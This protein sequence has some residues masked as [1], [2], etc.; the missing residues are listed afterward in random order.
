MSVSS[1]DPEVHADGWK[2]AA[3]PAPRGSGRVA[4]R[5]APQI[6]RHGLMT[7][8][9]LL[10]VAYIGL[11]AVWS[12][13]GL[14][15]TGPLAGTWVGAADED[16]ASWLVEGRTP[17]LDNLTWLGTKPADT[18]IKVVATAL[19]AAVVF[20]VWRSWRD[21]FLICFS[22]ILEACVFITAT[23]IVSRPRP[24]VPP[25]D[26]VSVGTS[27]PSGHAA[28]AAAYCAIAI[29]I[30]DHTRNVWIRTVT[31]ILAV[32]IPL[33]VGASRMYRGVHY[34]TDVVGGIVLGVTCAVVVALIARHTFG[35]SAPSNTTTQPDSSRR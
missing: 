26:E 16:V 14:L 6:T 5:R 28:A 20:R 3:K 10:V 2:A 8:A 1:G 25:L 31:V 35:T 30:F 24:G 11:T 15:V 12:G 33:M 17:A 9:V 4:H 34:L 22:L 7:A 29:V 13:L 19:I 32:A 18:G 23:A 27:F 21:P